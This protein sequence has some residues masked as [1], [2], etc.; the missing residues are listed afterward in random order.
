MSAVSAASVCTI[1]STSALAITNG[2]SASLENW[3]SM[4]SIQSADNQHWCGGTY[5]GNRIIL[6]AAHCL[7]E[8]NVHI[9]YGNE[10]LSSNP[11]KINI[12]DR[13]VYRDGV[14]AHGDIG[15][16]LLANEPVGLDAAQLSDSA[17]TANLNT[18]DVLGS[19][20]LGAINSRSCDWQSI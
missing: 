8:H 12:V 18:G 3:G 10:N 14:V 20:G 11:P 15:L 16:F 9:R 17:F 7:G 5:I 2:E 1:L 4:V 13:I 19:S 6:T